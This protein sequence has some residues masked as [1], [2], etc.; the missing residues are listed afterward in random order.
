VRQRFEARQP[1]EAAGSLDGVNEA[2]DVAEDLSVVRI[3]LEA[4]QLDV[5]NIE[6]SFVSVMNSRSRSSMKGGLSTRN[7]TGR[8]GPLRAKSAPVIK[9][10][11]VLVNGLILVAASKHCRKA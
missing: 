9:P 11:S 7:A 6:A 2:K 5:D 3:L 10:I 1:E 4:D 8:S